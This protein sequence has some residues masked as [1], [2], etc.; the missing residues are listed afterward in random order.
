MTAGTTATDHLVAYVGAGHGTVR[1]WR[2]KRCPG[3]WDRWANI[4][5]TCATP[6]PEDE[7]DRACADCHKCKCVCEDEENDE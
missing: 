6:P 3:V 7:C 1:A 2:C 5:G 4:S